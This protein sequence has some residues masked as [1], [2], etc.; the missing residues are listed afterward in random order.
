M[1]TIKTKE[2]RLTD[3]IKNILES[4]MEKG[5]SNKLDDIFRYKYK[6][7]HM[8]IS[9][10]D[11]L[12]ALHWEKSEFDENFNITN[13]DQFKDVCIFDY[14]KLPNLKENVRNYICFEVNDY[15]GYDEHIIKNVIFRVVSHEEDIV[16]DWGISRQ[17]LLATI[18]K[19]EFDWTN[20]FGIHL[21][22]KS[23]EGLVTKDGYCYREILYVST[24][25]NNAHNKMN[26]RY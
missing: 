1:F 20:V 7:M 21:T 14:M 17:D 18:I 23:D 13:G 16:T 8:L 2:P 26:Y 6:I 25:P 15:K 24:V 19:N 3:N 9:N 11:I 4:S 5:T 12:N 10:Q 22:K